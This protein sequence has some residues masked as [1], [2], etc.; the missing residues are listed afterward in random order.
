MHHGRVFAVI[1]LVINN[2]VGI[3]SHVGIGRNAVPDGF[4][5]GKLRCFF[6]TISTR[7]PC[8]G[9]C[10]LLRKVCTFQGL[11]GCFLMRSIH[12]VIPDHFAED[13][14]RMISKIAVDGYAVFG[15]SK[16]HPVRFNVDST[17]TLLQEKDVARHFCSRVCLEGR[18]R[19]ADCAKQFSPLRDIFPNL[20]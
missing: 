3:V 20:R 13:H 2:R 17:V 8:D 19:Q 14:F 1:H 5:F 6:R 9:I 4:T 11:T 12:G 15:L 18:V 10:Q 7:D 16:M